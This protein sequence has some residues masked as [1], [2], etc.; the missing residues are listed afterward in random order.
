MD[1]EKVTHR[2]V[3]NSVKTMPT[4]KYYLSF[5]FHFSKYWIKRF[6]ASALH[7][8][9][10]LKYISISRLRGKAIVLMYHRVL[11]PEEAN[12]CFSH[13][14]IV[15]S[16]NTFKLHIE[17]LNTH[18]TPLT[19]EQFERHLL[20]GE[21]FPRGACLITFDDGWI[22][23]Y[24]NALPILNELST[25]AV[26]FTATDYIGSDSAFWQERLG[27]LIY[28]TVLLGFGTEILQDHGILFSN[29][30]NE[31]ELRSEIASI[32]D[33]YRKQPYESV[34][35]LIADLEEV[36]RLGGYHAEVV[37]YDRFMSWEH[38]D[39]LVESGI[40]V[41]SHSCSH[42]ILTRLDP[43]SLDSELEASRRILQ[44]HLGHEIK[45]IAYPNGD[46][47]KSV[48][49]K[50][51]KYGFRLAFT[52]QEGFADL[53]TDNLLIPRINMHESATSTTALFLCRILRIF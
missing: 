27:H 18:F 22:D 42:R 24:S 5:M 33:W 52:T 11:L 30:Q 37:P 6:I 1:T 16:R 8:S 29:T 51:S 23:N 48:R 26:V 35:S 15:V 50:V 10:L 31:R 45:A 47:N 32:V 34:F 25:P 20:S 28:K 40:S 9:G 17:F 36:L 4:Y 38:I 44:D 12:Q 7:N 39:S 14:G 13:P 41:E 43:Q 46:F 53:T 2:V 21:P 49:E 19:L 3:V